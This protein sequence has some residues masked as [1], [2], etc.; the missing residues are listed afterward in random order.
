MSK[1]VKKSHFVSGYYEAKNVVHSKKSNRNVITEYNTVCYER[2]SKE[3]FRYQV[4]R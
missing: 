1:A 2:G 4:P 3:S